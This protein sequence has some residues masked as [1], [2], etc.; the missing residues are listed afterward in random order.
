MSALSAR[1]PRPIALTAVEDLARLAVKFLLAV[2]LFL[3]KALRDRSGDDQERLDLAEEN[4]P[5]PIRSLEQ[6]A[7]FQ[8]PRLA[9]DSAGQLHPLSE[10]A[11]RGL[12]GL[13]QVDIV[14]LDLLG[15][16]V[17]W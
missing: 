15:R 17:L 1:F 6:V 12:P 2:L 3:P 7:G 4:I 11:R 10:H 8:G 5:G 14:L 13:H 16:E 9:V